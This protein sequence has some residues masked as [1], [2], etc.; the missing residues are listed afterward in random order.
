MLSSLGAEDRHAL[1]ELF[2]GKD[3]V[4]VDRADTRR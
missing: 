4:E 1:E 2:G 3:R